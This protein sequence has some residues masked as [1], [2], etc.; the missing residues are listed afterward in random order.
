MKELNKIE[1]Y[2]TISKKELF[3]TI[4]EPFC[5]TALVIESK[6]PFPGYYHTVI[7]EKEELRPISIFIVAAS[8]LNEE[9]LMRTSHEV[10]KVFHKK[11]DAASGY[12]TV[13]N[14]R[15]SCIRV[16]FL[17]NYHDIP[18]LVKMFQHAGIRFLKYRSIKP[19]QGLI[20]INRYF[21]IENVS[22]GIYKNIEEPEINYIEIPVKLEWDTF[23]K[24]TLEMKRNMEDN[25]FDAAI[26]TIVRKNSIL[27][28]VRI[29]DQKATA[30]KLN[31][32]KAKYFDALKK[33]ELI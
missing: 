12:I 9:K 30:E 18:R 26:G 11:F 23:E 5:G 29:Y 13:F 2:G 8:R 10:K 6:F 1:T 21:I 14:E 25:K 20:K 4:E 15:R 27:D 33:L 16:K 22:Q 17:E 7:P 31:L 28:I 3:A 19:Y 24:I 32:I